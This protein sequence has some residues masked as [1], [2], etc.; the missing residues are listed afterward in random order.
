MTTRLCDYWIGCKTERFKDLENQW[1][2]TIKYSMDHG[3]TNV[4]IDVA[5]ELEGEYLESWCIDQHGLSAKCYLGED[6]S[7]REGEYYVEIS[8]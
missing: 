1:F 5:S 2:R 4:T 6:Y 3:D 8:W 7:T